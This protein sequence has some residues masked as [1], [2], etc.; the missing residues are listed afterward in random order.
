MEQLSN[1]GRLIFVEDAPG[2]LPVT[3]G[4]RL[5]SLTAR[6]SYRLDRLGLPYEI[7]ADVGLEATLAQREAAY[8]EEQLAWFE[9]L[10][11]MLLERLP[12]LKQRAIRPTV[13]YG[14]WL[15]LLLDDLFIRGCEC[16]VEL[17]K[18]PARQVI[19]W[20]CLPS[21]HV[22]SAVSLRTRV[23]YG[24]LLRQ[25][26]AARGMDYEER[27][28][29]HAPPEERTL[30]VDRGRSAGMALRRALRP[31]RERFWN[32][33]AA[34]GFFRSHSRRLTLLLLET[35]AELSALLHQGL[36]AGQRCL[37]RRGD[38][39]IDPK[40]RA[41][42]WPLA[43]PEG[44]QDPS[45]T[46]WAAAA[47]HLCASASPI[48]TWLEGW[49]GCSMAPLLGP[50]LHSWIATELPRMVSLADRFH[51]LYTEERIDLVLLSSLAESAQIAAVAATRRPGRTQSVLVSHGAGPDLAA[52][53]DLF[54]VFPPHHYVVPH[55]EL[56]EHFRQR[57]AGYAQP[58]AQIHVGSSRWE[59]L[60]RTGRRA[61]VSVRPRPLLIYM[62][63]RPEDNL[64]YLN[65][66][67]CSDPWYYRLQ[68]ALIRLLAET[69]QYRVVVKLF[70]LSERWACTV[71]QV[72][73]DAGASHLS[74]SQAPFSWWLQRADRVLMDW[75]STPLYETALAGVPFHALVHRRF[76][77]R[78]G[79]LEI[80]KPF[81]TVF[82][83][84]AEAVE[85][86]RRYLRAPPVRWSLPRTGVAGLLETVCGLGPV[87]AGEATPEPDAPAVTLT[88]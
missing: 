84:T 7:P 17:E 11:A 61:L 12:P 18:A 57:R 88:G 35:D 26:C 54:D 51:Q 29:A 87:R 85:A 63:G 1:A 59:R 40:R 30:P 24:R 23:T 82:E 67:E 55:E 76:A 74:V 19:L 70:P 38:R 52:A 43:A 21:G 13:L 9:R 69:P 44:R 14:Y 37:V 56:A 72:V 73:R 65:K 66:P 53:W 2:R 71:E 64:R 83:E 86:V 47:E 62:I 68:T 42:Q 16:A 22:E 60:A 46:R 15:K 3:P 48:W 4:D 20:T 39:V 80:F 41:W 75:P 33:Q 25:L 5:V 36:L 31:C 77:M 50:Q 32:V 49:M 8:W 45:S 58:M 34:L 81:L 27:L 10:D 6:A 28:T 78:P 79:A